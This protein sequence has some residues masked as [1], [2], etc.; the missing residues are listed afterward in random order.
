MDGAEFLQSA[1]NLYFKRAVHERDIAGL[2]D[3][4]YRIITADASAWNDTA[5]MHRDLAEVFDFPAHDGRNY[6]GHVDEPPIA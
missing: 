2:R 6:P 1:V 3:I 5:D 4:G